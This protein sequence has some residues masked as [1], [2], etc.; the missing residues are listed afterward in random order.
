MITRQRQTARQTQMPA[1]SQ[2]LTNLCAADAGLR[3]ARRIDL[4]QHA[5]SILSFVRELCDKR[6][7]ASIVDGLAQHSA[8]EPFDVQIFNRDQAKVVDQPAANAM[9]EV[10]PLFPHE[11][12]SA[13]QERHSIASTARA[14][15]AAAD[16]PSGHS[17]GALGLP[18]IARVLNSRS[19][20]QRCE[21]SQAHVNADHVRIEWQRFGHALASKHR[22]PVS[23]FALNRQRLNR[24]PQGP[25]H[26]DSDITDLRQSQFV[27]I[28][29][30]SNLPK[31]HAV[32][33]AK[34]SESRVAWFLPRLH[35]S[36]EAVKRTFYPLQNILKYY[37]AQDFHVWANGANTRHLPTLREIR[38]ALSFQSPRVPSL[39][40]RR[41]VEFTADGK[42]IVERLNLALC[43]I[44]SVTVSPCH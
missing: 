43:R 4:H 22:K 26:F 9:V 11:R 5:S 33:A 40:K 42:V 38:N 19:I 2:R 16:A 3:S 25:S 1:I 35:A 13:L 24:P 6:R 27:S 7:P 20:A 37:G 29:R 39:L 17:Q 15:L 14:F 10:G 44:N 8:S 32:V 12:V 41:V 18:I 34:R 30:V 31:R 23:A 21:V 36:K 28:Q